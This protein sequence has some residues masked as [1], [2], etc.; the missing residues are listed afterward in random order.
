M[1]RVVFN[2]KG[3]VGK[4][5]IA[6][7]LAAIAATRGRRTLLID[8]DPQG[9]AS[10]YLLGKA[11][12]EQKKTLAHFFEDILGYKLFPE[13]LASYVVVTPFADL[14]VLPSDPRLEEVQ[15]KLESRYKMYKLREALDKLQGYDEIFIDTPPALNFF[16]RSALIAADTCLIPFDCD[17]F[18]RRAL[19]SLMDSVRE[20]QSD[21]NPALR[22]EG[23]VVNQYQARANLPLRLVDELR[24]E[25]LP[26]LDAFLSA[27][28][29][30]RESHHL[31][32]PMIHLDPRHKLS[33][34]FSALL[35]PAVSIGAGAGDP[36]PDLAI[37][38]SVVQQPHVAELA[39]P[40][41]LHVA[42]DS[43]AM[44]LPSGT[45]PSP[46][47]SLIRM[48]DIFGQAGAEKAESDRV[49]PGWS[50]RRTWAAAQVLDPLAARCGYAA[51]RASDWREVQ[52]RVR[53]CPSLSSGEPRE[54]EPRQIN[55]RVDAGQR[56]L[57]RSPD[58]RHPGRSGHPCCGR[59]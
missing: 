59:R 39:Q 31:A 27:S 47:N 22:V 35:R 44:A 14:A 12:D 57:R 24:A 25:G 54:G 56:I 28:I 49:P 5:T 55:S 43:C 2:Q 50:P 11:L 53:E 41:T 9:N 23:I 32:Q 6:C 52:R 33:N 48:V 30:I 26:I 51:E 21:H 8:L 13:T 20:I 7:N 38:P 4:S 45:R 36:L 3:G 37:H 17:D 18:S 40:G 16:T 19:Y 58:R 46:T 29:K 42:F 34:E 10:R 15:F 1:R